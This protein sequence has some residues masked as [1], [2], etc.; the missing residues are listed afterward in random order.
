MCALCG[1]NGVI[2][3]PFTTVR[4]RVGVVCVPRGTLQGKGDGGRAFLGKRG[5]LAGGGGGGGRAPE[6]SVG[7]AAFGEE[8]EDEAGVVGNGVAGAPVVDGFATGANQGGEF[9][10]GEVDGAKGG[11]E[12]GAVHSFMP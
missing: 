2:G 6:E 5:G 7:S 11:A 1:L 4:R 12:G 9:V 3:R 8:G 10:G